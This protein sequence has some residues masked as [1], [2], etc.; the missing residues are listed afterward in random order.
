MAKKKVKE[1]TPLTKDEKEFLGA[2]RTVR[3][4][5]KVIEQHENNPVVQQAR[6]ERD[7]GVEAIEKM[8]YGDVGDDDDE[9]DW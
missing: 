8:L 9:F 2:Y 4:S 5:Q 3:D 7:A 1:F 6:R